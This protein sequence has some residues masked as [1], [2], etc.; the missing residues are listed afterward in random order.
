MR[1]RD[2]T[3]A[4]PVRAHGAL[5]RRRLTQARLEKRSLEIVSRV[6]KLYAHKPSAASFV[7][8]ANAVE[9]AG[10]WWEFVDQLIARYADGFVRAA[11]DD[12]APAAIGYPR[13]W[14]ER[15]GYT[16]ADSAIQFA[17]PYAADIPTA[18]EPSAIKPLLADV[19]P[20]REDIALLRLAAGGEAVEG[21]AAG[22]EAATDDP[23]FSRAG[24]LAGGVAVGSVA[25]AALF[26]KMSAWREAAMMRAAAAAEWELSRP[27][28]EYRP[29]A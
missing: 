6:D 16:P 14:L 29:M 11:P 24:W 19:T 8:A 3:H 2:L 22:G 12:A 18:L 15:V 25:G 23:S 20:L 28:T 1:R 21:E 13:E 9:T 4:V 10:R 17:A 26:A 7:Y 27:V 5:R